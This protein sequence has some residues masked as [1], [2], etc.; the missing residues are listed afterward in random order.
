MKY[1]LVSD[2][3][4]N[5]FEM[6]GV[7]YSSVPLKIIFGDKEYV[8]QPGID[9]AKMV[10]ELEA[11]K[12]HSGTSCPNVQE[13]YDAFGDADCAFGVAITSNL[14]GSWGAG[15]QAARDYEENNPGKRA[16]ILDSLSAGPA[17]CLMLEDARKHIQAGEDFETI[18]AAMIESQKHNKLAFCL[19]SLQNLAR[20]G[21]VSPAVAK[22][23]SILGIRMVGRASTVGTLEPVY[24]PRG[25]QKA[26]ET[27]L[28]LMEEDGY[29][30]GRVHITHGL[31]LP[32]A[33]AL[34]DL[35]LAKYPN[36]QITV[37]D[38][39]GLCT[40]YAEKG[41]VMVGFSDL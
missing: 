22:I 23:A 20:N 13:W 11:H 33:Q 29:K 28:Q 2:S 19:Q 3:S 26:L 15:A 8:D 21:R 32:A 36:T 16:F 6:S 38:N 27:V 5:V 25:E 37:A 10:A 17:L 41:G 30:G 39:T 40:F 1:K 12:G 31:N 9:T 35:I 18:K 7:D 24:K 4:S 34:R 14:S